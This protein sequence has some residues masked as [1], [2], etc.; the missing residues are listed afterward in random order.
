MG[1]AI[2]VQLVIKIGMRIQVKDVQIGVGMVI[3][4]DQGIG[5]GVIAP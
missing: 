4:P 2:A 1:V 5:H 3:A